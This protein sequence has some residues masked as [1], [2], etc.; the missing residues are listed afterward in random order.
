MIKTQ[1]WIPDELHILLRIA[2]VLFECFFNEITT[3]KNFKNEILHEIEQIMKDIKVHFEFFAP[4]TSGGKWTWKSLMGP[5]K[6]TIL[7][8]FPVSTF[9]LGERGQK[10]ELLW[11]E[12]YRLY[13]VMKKE[14]LTFDEID[15]FEKD[16]KNWVR[17]FCC[18]TI[19]CQKRIIQEGIYRA[20]D[21]T[22]Y[23]HVFAQ[24]VPQFMRQLKQRGLSFCHF[25]TLSIEKK[26]HEQVSIF[27]LKFQLTFT[28]FLLNIGK[29]ILWW[30]FN[31]W[32]KT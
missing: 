17:L 16:A 21:V 30:N 18:P 27:N 8:K 13:C 7:E 1:N 22:P 32:W 5:A 19:F 12:F 2:D 6:K 23:M 28:K 15:E 29:V 14:N 11:R 9:I 31:G 3:R 24:H 4:K 25:T 20:T 10:I 26:N